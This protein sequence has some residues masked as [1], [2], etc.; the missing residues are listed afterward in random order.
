MAVIY[1]L[2]L[3]IIALSLSGVVFMAKEDIALINM[4]HPL[5]KNTP[6]LVS[7]LTYIGICFLLAKFSLYMAKFLSSDS[8]EQA[9]IQKLE[10]ANDTFLPS[11]LGYFFVAL[12][13]P[14]VELFFFVFGII[15]VFVFFSRAAVA[16]S[17]VA[18]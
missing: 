6:H 18:R 7:F 9:S 5:V 11:F 14:N 13:I 3:T 17:M 10:Q 2:F 16:A 12:S 15:V 4:L 8:I 1:R